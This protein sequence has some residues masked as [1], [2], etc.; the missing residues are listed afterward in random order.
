MIGERIVAIF[1]GIE[2]AAASHLEGDDVR[3][4]VIVLTPGFGIEIYAMHARRS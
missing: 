1:A 4:A 3:W 2:Q